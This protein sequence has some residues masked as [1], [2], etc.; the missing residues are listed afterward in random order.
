MQFRQDYFP[1]LFFAKDHRSTNAQAGK[2]LPDFLKKLHSQK[3][4]F[5]II[6]A[7]FK[8]LFLPDKF[9]D[10]SFTILSFYLFPIQNASKFLYLNSKK[11]IFIK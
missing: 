10:V 4:L 3:R 9:K 1:W 11:L 5:D 6:S 7:A 8:R 2:R